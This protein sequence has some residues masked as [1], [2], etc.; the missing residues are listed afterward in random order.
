MQAEVLE[1]KPVEDPELSPS[2]DLNYDNPVVAWLYDRVIGPASQAYAEDL[3]E[4]L[5]P[6]FAPGSSLLDV[7]CGGGQV[8]SALAERHPALRLTGIDLSPRQVALARKRVAA[9]SNRT[10]VIEGSA[11]NLPFP[12]SHFDAV[13]SLASIKHWP[14]PATGLRECIRVL[15]PGGRLVVIELDRGCRFEDAQRFIARCRIPSSMATPVL[16]GFR[17]FAIGQAIDLEDARQ[18]AM[19]IGL[20]ESE[21]RRLPGA[22]VLMIRGQKP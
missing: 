11:E 20:D 15:K 12:T 17:T 16:M 4:W 2:H 13:I 21:V 10:E 1:V 7:G 5:P 6:D 9:S 18:L 14:N 22:P 3:Y 19:N 8:L